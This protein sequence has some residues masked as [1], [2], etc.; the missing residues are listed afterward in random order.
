[1]ISKMSFPIL[2]FVVALAI[3]A[4]FKKKAQPTLPFPPGPRKYPLIGNLLD[5]PNKHQWLVYDR[6]AREYSMWPVELLSCILK[7]NKVQQIRISS[8]SKCSENQ[9]S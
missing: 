5:V 8:T 9:S 1:M 7:D 4:Y 3:V 6:I 2:L